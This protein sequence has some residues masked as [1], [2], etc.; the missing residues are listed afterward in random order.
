MV[1][2]TQILPFAIGAGANVMSPA[3]YAAL[4]AQSTG[5]V[6]GIAQSVQF[7]TT[8]R[9]AAFMSAALANFLVAEGITQNDDGNLA[10]AVTNIQQA[11]KQLVGSPTV[12]T[13]GTTTGSANSQVMAT[14]TPTGWALTNG[15]TIIGTAGYTNTG[16]MQFTGP[17]GAIQ[18]VKKLSGS[19]YVALV[20][21]EFT[22]TVNFSLT[23]NTTAN[24]YI[25]SSSTALGALAYLNAGFGVG[26]DG[27]GNLALKVAQQPAGNVSG[28]KI[29]YTTANTITASA[30]TVTALVS[31]LGLSYKGSSL[32]A[33]LNIG[34][35]GANGMDTGTAT[36][37]VALHV[38]WIYNPTTN[39][40]ALLG[41]NSGTG[42]S[43]YPGSNMPAGYTASWLATS[44]CLNSS[45]QFTQFTA[46][47]G[48]VYFPSIANIISGINS[49]GSQAVPAY[50]PPNATAIGGVLGTVSPGGF[51]IAGDANYTG[52][53]GVSQSVSIETP[54]S[55]LPIFTAS[56]L[57]YEVT[58]GSPG[59]YFNL[60]S[61]KL[62]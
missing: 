48:N 35:T 57:F 23:W 16:A 49:N 33:V 4:A 11:I 40:W 2:T 42:A 41:T 10:G 22:A 18:T 17:D 7:N 47:S 53:Q 34:T 21:G 59:G 30:D 3:A 51:F 50:I 20:G 15:Y 52:S 26:S 58:A 19:S 32:S 39:T 61:Y 1:A 6:S 60:S 37:S 25:W 43:I 29:A 13:G 56:T 9:Q 27:S 38:Y 12:F 28:Q 44:V 62:W 8:L 31:L 54:C 14:V 36:A 5:Y 46:R 24:A 45:S 55:N